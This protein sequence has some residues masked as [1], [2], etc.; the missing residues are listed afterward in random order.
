MKIILTIIIINFLYSQANYQIL[1]SAA[2][3]DEIFKNHKIEDEEYSFFHTS[4]PAQID[5]Y[6]FSVSLNRII[7]KQRYDFYLNFQ[8]LDYGTI[9]DNISNYTFT[10]NENLAQILTAYNINQ[11]LRYMFGVGFINSKIDQYSSNAVIIEALISYQFS[12]NIINAKLENYG[13]V[14]NKYTSSNIDLPSLISIS[15][16]KNLNPITII[17][18]YEYDLSLNEDLYSIASNFNIKNNLNLYVGF[19]SNKKSLIYGDYI[20]ELLSGIRFGMSFK[21]SDYMFYIASQNMGAAGY[22]NSI[23]IKKINL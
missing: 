6:S 4:Y 9:V 22:S 8:S 11:N 10:A 20:D 14:L 23:S 19:N 18:N 16:N 3:F 21:F 2:S 13:M 15:Y 1:N 17:M 7:N 12:N 5:S